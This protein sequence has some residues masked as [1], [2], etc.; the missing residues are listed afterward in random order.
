M[1]YGTRATF[2]SIREVAFGSITASFT[3]LGSALSNHG[4]V[5]KLT[6]GTNA[7]IYVSIDGVNAFDKIPAN[8]YLLIDFATNRIRDDGLF[9]AI[10]TQFYIR[11]DTAPTSGAFWMSTVYAE[12][13]V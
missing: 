7:P 6:N 2:D 4:R 5:I 3:A 10:G 8:G 11:Y 13:G 12:G 1:A 9:I